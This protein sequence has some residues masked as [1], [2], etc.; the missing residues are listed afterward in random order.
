MVRTM[1][2]EQSA[3]REARPAASKRVPV[4][5]LAQLSAWQTCLS[6]T[7]PK[8]PVARER[9]K[10]NDFMVGSV[11]MRLLGV[12]SNILGSSRSEMGDSRVWNH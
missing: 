2:L 9:K 4:T 3:V 5:A 12:S 11:D 10:M 8:D 7:P 1:K 6:S